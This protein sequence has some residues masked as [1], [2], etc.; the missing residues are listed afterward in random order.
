MWSEQG[1]QVTL[2]SVANDTALSEYTNN[3]FQYPGD[4]TTSRL[5]SGACGEEFQVCIQL[6]PTFRQ[7]T[8]NALKV[9]IVCHS[10][11]EGG[12]TISQCYAIPLSNKHGGIEVTLDKWV[13]WDHCQSG[14]ECGRVETAYSLPGTLSKSSVSK[15]PNVA[16][17]AGNEEIS[18]ASIE[19]TRS[20]GVANRGCVV[21]NIIRGKLALERAITGIGDRGSLVP[22][23]PPE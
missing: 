13:R 17:P 9:E 11:G 8:A 14:P 4:V 10:V 22:A 6:D 16:K 21:V 5:I 23:T 2:K 7:Y 15:T 12:T 20:Y 18:C 3:H 1:I 19:W